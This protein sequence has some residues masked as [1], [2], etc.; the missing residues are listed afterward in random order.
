VK[1][2]PS[3]SERLTDGIALV[4]GGGAP[5]EAMTIGQASAVAYALAGARVVIADLALE[6]AERSA[7]MIRS[8]G[9]EALACSADVI[10]ELSVAEAVARTIDRFGR[11]DV[12]HNNVGLPM[13]RAFD[14]Y[15]LADWERG[16]RINCIGAASTIRLALP[17]LLESE[18][19]IVNVSSVAA[20]RHTGMNYAVYNASKGALD[21]LTVAVALEYAH[22][23]LRANAILPGLI[24]TEMGRGLGQD[25]G[26]TLAHRARKSPTGRQG[27][28]W[29][30]A[31]AAV[32]LASAEAKYINGHL[33]VVDGGLTRR[34]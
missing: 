32:F 7:A 6:N 4:F 9:G 12:L 11:I 22:R 28:V 23:G 15:G 31:N 19:A 1:G 13:A 10:D 21:Q 25:A 34:C 3:R 30:V 2:H 14:D 20:I 33:L 5:S 17:H 24:D 29:D 8:L 27:D 18:G 26:D 16:L